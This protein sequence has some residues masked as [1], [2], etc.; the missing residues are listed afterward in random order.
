[1]RDTPSRKSAQAKTTVFPEP[2]QPVGA[3]KVRNFP[4][5]SWDGIGVML[6]ATIL[7]GVN[8]SPPSVDFTNLIE[9][10]ANQTMWTVPSAAT[11]ISGAPESPIP[12]K[13]VPAGG[14]VPPTLMPFQIAPWPV[15]RAKLRA[16]PPIPAPSSQAAEASCLCVLDG[17]VSA[18]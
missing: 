5:G 7:G 6:P 4:P 14:S 11:E 10:P 13:C 2:V 15:D 1:M 12:G 16:D 9:S 17:F 18:A 8:D 3:L